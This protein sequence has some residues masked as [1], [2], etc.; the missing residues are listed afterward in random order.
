MF[1]YKEETSFPTKEQRMRSSSWLYLGTEV[2]QL[3]GG[4]FNMLNMIGDGTDSPDAGEEIQPF[5]F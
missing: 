2:V 3:H 4:T 1:K 5:M